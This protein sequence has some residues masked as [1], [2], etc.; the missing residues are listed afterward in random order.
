MLRFTAQ[1]FPYSTDFAHRPSGSDPVLAAKRA[2]TAKL[3]NEY[4][5]LRSL[6]VVSRRLELHHTGERLLV[7][8]DADRACAAELRGLLGVE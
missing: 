2:E 8:V 7:D 1:R 3:L 4:Q 5:Q 6:A